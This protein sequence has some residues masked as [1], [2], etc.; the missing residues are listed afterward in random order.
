MLDSILSDVRHVDGVKLRAISGTLAVLR[1][2]LQQP[3]AQLDQ[4]AKV[5]VPAR[6][7][8]GNAGGGFRGGEGSDHAVMMTGLGVR[9]TAFIVRPSAPIAAG[10]AEC[11]L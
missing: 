2:S 1:M 3:V 7:M 10:S 4:R 6:V 5:P 9:R 11:A 8:G